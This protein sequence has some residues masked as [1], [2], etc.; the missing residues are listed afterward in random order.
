L[1]CGKKVK[2]ARKTLRQGPDLDAGLTQKQAMMV[3]GGVKP[4]EH[5]GMRRDIGV[6]DKEE[7]S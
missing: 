2:M 1:I 3:Q 6:A 7:I 4:L 5:C